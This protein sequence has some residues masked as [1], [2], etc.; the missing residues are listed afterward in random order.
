MGVPFDYK[1]PAFH[2]N[3]LPITA[4]GFSL[5]SLPGTR[6]Q[7]HEARAIESEPHGYP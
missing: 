3:L 2:F 5:Q 7:E 4:K 1:G 6:E